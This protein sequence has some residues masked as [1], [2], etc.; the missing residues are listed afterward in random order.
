MLKE[1]IFY[2]K[3]LLPVHFITLLR[4]MIHQNVIQELAKQL[5]KRSWIGLKP[6]AKKS[7]FY[8]CTGQPGQANQLLLKLLRSY[9]IRVAFLQ[10]V[11]FS[12]G[13][14]LAV[15]TLLFSFQ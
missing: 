1:S 13:Q 14:R 8:G 6:S 12:R 15:T 2:V 4:G 10:P 5:S 11:S 9:V 3:R 7:S